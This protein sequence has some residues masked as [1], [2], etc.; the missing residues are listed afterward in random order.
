MECVSFKS[1]NEQ[2]KFFFL[3]PLSSSEEILIKAHHPFRAWV[4]YTSSL[5]WWNLPDRCVHHSISLTSTERWTQPL[6]WFHQ[7]TFSHLPSLNSQDKNLFRIRNN[8]N[9]QVPKP[10][11]TRIG[12]PNQDNK[13]NVYSHVRKAW[14]RKRALTGL[15]GVRCPRHNIAPMIMRVT[16][17]ASHGQ[18]VA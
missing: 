5:G 6:G 12:Q 11:R 18:Q 4:N 15:I 1:G 9:L 17:G 13:N 7:A 2:R 8:K 10:S 14:P 16:Q 3:P